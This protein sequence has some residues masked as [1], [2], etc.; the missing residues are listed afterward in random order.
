MAQ[1][2]IM[3][4]TEEPLEEEIPLDDEENEPRINNGRQEKK[5]PDYY[6]CDD[7]YSCF[8]VGSLSSNDNSG[9]DIPNS[10]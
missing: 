5:T 6:E 7:D 8:D 9:G 10:T 4:G 1:S 2:D 3:S